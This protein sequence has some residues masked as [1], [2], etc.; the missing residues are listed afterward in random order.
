MLLLLQ[1][2]NWGANQLTTEQLQYAALDAWLGLQLAVRLHQLALAQQSAAMQSTKKPAAGASDKAESAAAAVVRDPFA[3]LATFLAPYVLQASSS[4]SNSHCNSR[5]INGYEMLS[6]GPVLPIKAG[7]PQQQQQQRLNLQQQNALAVPMLPWL[8][9][10]L[11]QQARASTAGY[12]LPQQQQLN[13]LLQQQ[14]QGSHQDILQQQQREAR[15]LLQ[16]AQQQLHLQQY[17]KAFSQLQYLLQQQRQLQLRQQRSVRLKHRQQASQQQQQDAA[18]QQQAAL[19]QQRRQRQL[20]QLQRLGQAAAALP[21]RN[22]FAKMQQLKPARLPT[23]KS[24]QYENCRILAPD[25]RP[26]ATCGIKKV[27]VWCCACCMHVAGCFEGKGNLKYSTAKLWGIM[28]VKMQQLKPAR[29]PTRKRLQ[30]E[31]CR[32]LAPDGRPHATCGIKKV[33]VCRFKSCGCAEAKYWG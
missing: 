23:R 3:E 4:I 26:L 28:S 14:Q 31:N 16:A 15:A 1:C 9:P 8:M 6:R 13:A 32:I 30:Y 10:V 18:S 20:E 27:R 7:K 12:H 33:C 25:G 19:L 17:C 11:Q 21:S 5:G 24:T 29:L 2:S 22:V